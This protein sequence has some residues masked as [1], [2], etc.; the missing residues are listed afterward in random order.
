MF[1]FLKGNALWHL[2]QQSDAISKMVLLTL[3]M[4]SVL[5]WSVFF[6]K[7]IL[8]RIKKRQIK[9]VRAH[10]RGARTLEDVTKV[11]KTFEQTFPGYILSRLLIFLKTLLGDGSTLTVYQWEQIQMYIDQVLD[12]VMHYEESFM[13]ILSTCAA[14]SPLLGLFGTV[15]GLV[16]AFV[17]ISEQQSTDIAA[18]APGIAEALMTTLAGLVVAIPALIMFNYVSSRI[19]SL[20]QDVIQLCDRV[21]ALVRTLVS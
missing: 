21:N 5:C 7:V 14:V 6:Y 9:K 4:M 19:R 12:E 13:A 11:V 18:V 20:E 1:S 17:G 8:V 2:V 10:L 3:L 16:H 15:W